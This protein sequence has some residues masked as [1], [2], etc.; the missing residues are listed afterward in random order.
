MA[1]SATRSMVE[2]TAPLA[3]PPGARRPLAEPAPSDSGDADCRRR[4]TAAT[5]LADEEASE[6]DSWW[7][8]NTERQRTM[9]AMAPTRRSFAC[10]RRSVRCCVARSSTRLAL[11][12]ADAAALK[13]F[14][15]ADEQA[16]GARRVCARARRRARVPEAS[17][18]AARHRVGV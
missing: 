1:V 18:H 3:P 5:K 6:S 17:A 2:A 7:R 10:C 11:D 15:V 9:C 13:T 16:R 14:A 4:S 12:V 8:E